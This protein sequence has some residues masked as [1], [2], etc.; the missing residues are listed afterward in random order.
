[1]TLDDG[2]LNWHALRV[3][4][5]ATDYQF[6]RFHCCIDDTVKRKYQHL[7]FSRYSISPHDLHDLDFGHQKKVWN[8]KP[9]LKAILCH[10]SLTV[11]AIGS[12][13]MSTF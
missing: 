6:A 5:F 11:V 10:V 3:K 9:S 12:V 1:M 4:N 2:H 7:S 13:K 8:S